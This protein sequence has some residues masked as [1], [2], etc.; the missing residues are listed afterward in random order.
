MAAVQK[1]TS[2]KNMILG[3]VS[4][5]LWREGLFGPLVAAANI[6]FY[7]I[8]PREIAENR[9]FNKVRDQYRPHI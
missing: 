7:A 3:R 1:P 5:V 4:E 8:N 2:I 6:G 9:S